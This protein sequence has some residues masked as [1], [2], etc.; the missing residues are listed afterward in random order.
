M[1]LLL[2]PPGLCFLFLERDVNV[3][4]EAPG[5]PAALIG[6]EVGHVG[7]GPPKRRENREKER[8]GRGL[9]WLSDH[10]GAEDGHGHG[11]GEQQAQQP[12][13]D[14]HAGGC[15]R[16]RASPLRVVG[17]WAYLGPSSPPATLP[18]FYRKRR[19]WVL[20]WGCWPGQVVSTSA[21]PVAV[22]PSVSQEMQEGSCGPQQRGHSFLPSF[23]QDMVQV[24]MA[25][26]RTKGKTLPWGRA[27]RAGFTHPHAF[28]VR[29]TVTLPTG[30]TA[31]W[32]QG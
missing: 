14:L 25:L 16:I 21:E 4:L 8:G 10:L 19:G 22:L 15:V 9:T 30:G 17:V 27:Q 23:L 20:P 31:E 18:A 7:L 12:C 1:G 3:K 13:R 6:W 24:P 28:S 29:A 2:S 26:L 32:P 5:T 11:H